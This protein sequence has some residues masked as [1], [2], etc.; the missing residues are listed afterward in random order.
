MQV[1]YEKQGD[2]FKFLCNVKP[3]LINILIIKPNQFSG[4]EPVPPKFI[5][6]LQSLTIKEGVTSRFECRVSGTPKPEVSWFKDNVML[7]KAQMTEMDHDGDDKY[8]IALKEA[9]PV[10][11]GTFTCMAENIAGRTISGAELHVVEGNV[12]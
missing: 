12:D 11:S 8:W 2:F 1:H 4:E 5:E 10:D 6:P 9:L 3:P 7:Q